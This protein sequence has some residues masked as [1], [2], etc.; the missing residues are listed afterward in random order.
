NPHYFWWVTP[1]IA[2]LITAVPLSVYTS[3]VSAGERARRWGLFHIPE[4]TS[5]PAELRDLHTLLHAARQ[6]EGRLPPREH[7]GFVRAV[8]DPFVNAL[9]RA[10]LGRRR[11]QRATIRAAR[12]A[13]VE[14]ALADGP[15]ALA[16]RQRRI[17]LLDPDATDALHE[18][19]WEL[20]ER[21]RAARWGRPGLTAP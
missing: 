16:A 8:V 3:R 6:Q 19:V 14:R 1:I 9:H 7:D 5:P 17:L 18:A 11:S 15:E 20:P 10:L 12:A 4:E 21:E 13:L 2:A